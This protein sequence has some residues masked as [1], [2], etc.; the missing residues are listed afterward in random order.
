MLS[1][2]SAHPFPSYDED[3]LPLIVPNSFPADGLGAKHFIPLGIDHTS[4]AGS[5]HEDPKWRKSEDN[6]DVVHK[7]MKVV[8]GFL[9]C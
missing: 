9:F 2:R 7:N 6:I 4:S 8:R 3:S 5:L 1:D